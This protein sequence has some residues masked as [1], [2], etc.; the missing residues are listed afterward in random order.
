MKVDFFLNISF[1]HFVVTVK[2]IDKPKKKRLLSLRHQTKSLDF[3]RIATIEL[4]VHRYNQLPYIYNVTIKIQ[5]SL[6]VLFVRVS[7]TF[8]IQSEFGGY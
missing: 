8:I 4:G 7:I 2:L 3:M 5:F 6:Y 1:A